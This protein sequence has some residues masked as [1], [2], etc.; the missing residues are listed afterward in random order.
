MSPRQRT[1]AI[2]LPPAGQRR[3]EYDVTDS[4]RVSSP[5]AVRDAVRE[6]FQQACPG[7]AFDVLWLAFHDFERLFRGG[8]G[9]YLG[10]DTVYHDMQHTLDV[11]LAMARLLA[12]HEASRPAADRLG[13][14][15]ALIGL[16]TALYHDAGYIRRRAEAHVL[17]GAEF[18]GRHVSR[19][20]AFLGSY[21][22]RVGLGA[23]AADVMKIVHFTG[24]EMDLDAIELDDPRD[25]GPDGADG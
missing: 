4:V 13:E 9:D 3:S 18:T 16:L 6:L 25:C 14:E 22:P 1:R 2:E 24:Y 19:S 8:Y 11:T 23:R 7:A 15:R 10:C 12:G 5:A 20:A 21:L 17:N